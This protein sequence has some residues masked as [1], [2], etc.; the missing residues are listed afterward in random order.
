MITD[1]LLKKFGVKKVYENKIKTLNDVDYAFDDSFIDGFNSYLLDDKVG[2]RVDI[3]KNIEL[4]I[5]FLHRNIPTNHI[6]FEE[7][8]ALDIYLGG[9]DKNDPYIYSY[10]PLK[11]NYY[12]KE[13]SI[14]EKTISFTN[15]YDTAREVTFSLKNGTTYTTSL[16]VGE[17]FDYTFS[18]DSELDELDEIKVEDICNLD[19]PIET[20]CPIEDCD[21]NELVNTNAPT[22]FNTED[23]IE[24]EENTDVD[25]LVI[26]DLLD[27]A[28]TVGYRA[29]YNPDYHVYFNEYGLYRG[30]FGDGDT[31]TTH[32]FAF[33]FLIEARTKGLLDIT[34]ESSDIN[35]QYMTFINDNFH[36]EKIRISDENNDNLEPQITRRDVYRIYFDPI[37]LFG[38]SCKDS[39]YKILLSILTGR[40]PSSATHRFS[41]DNDL[42]VSDTNNCDDLMTRGEISQINANDAMFKYDVCLEIRK[43]IKESKGL[44]KLDQWGLY[45][46]QWYK[47]DY[48]LVRWIESVK[49]SFRELDFKI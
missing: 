19:T 25:E 9:G 27:E 13:D 35:H 46:I 39:S 44:Y 30:T 18:V 7:L 8:K 24:D 3:Y 15:T 10:V 16:E 28:D 26:P 12:W 23:V 32:S 45:D 1:D 14:G 49:F 41:Y 29:L 42:P 2:L 21:S 17:S 47:R 36:I 34:I 40:S 43:R 48:K 38:N 5:S 22:F 6:R 20:F 33:R 4:F 11:K 31:F 37:K